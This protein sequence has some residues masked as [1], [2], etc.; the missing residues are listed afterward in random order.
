MNTHIEK[1]QDFGVHLP[2]FALSDEYKEKLDL[3]TRFALSA[4]SKDQS[5]QEIVDKLLE[6][7]PVYMVAIDQSNY[8]NIVFENIPDGCQI[9]LSASF[10]QDTD[11]CNWLDLYCLVTNKLG[12]VLPPQ[13]PFE[14]YFSDRQ[15]DSWEILVL[16]CKN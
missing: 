3:I 13:T 2:N 10:P 4:Y 11:G 14:G 12:E 9:H 1:L 7:T 5:V 6:T 8:E 15:V 16:F